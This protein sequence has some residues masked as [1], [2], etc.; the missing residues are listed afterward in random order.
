MHALGVV[1]PNIRTLTPLPVQRVR[2][3]S[4]VME[5]PIRRSVCIAAGFGGPIAVVG[6]RSP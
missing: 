4:T 6:L 1:L 5:S 3:A 2:L